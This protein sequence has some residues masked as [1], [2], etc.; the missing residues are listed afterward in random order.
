MSKIQHIGT[1]ACSDGVLA[2]YRHPNN[3]IFA[4][5]A[6]YVEQEAG[7]T[8]DPFDGLEFDATAAEEDAGS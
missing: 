4:I 7:P 8:F 6:S 2:V 3:G 5:D 1:F